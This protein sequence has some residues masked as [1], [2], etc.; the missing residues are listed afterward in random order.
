MPGSPVPTLASTPRSTPKLPPPATIGVE[1]QEA[2]L[3]QR[4]KDAALGEVFAVIDGH[5][6][7]R[8]SDAG[9]LPLTT[10]DLPEGEP[11][12]EDS[13]WA[14]AIDPKNLGDFEGF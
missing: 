1:A 6:A 13:I 4:A 5:A 12:T 3:P 7:P 8:P 11:S 9:A 14:G 10:P 2:L